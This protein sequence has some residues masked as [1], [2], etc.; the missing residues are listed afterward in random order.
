MMG[1]RGGKFHRDDKTLGRRRWATHHWI[2]C[3]L[4]WKGQH[5]EPMG[6]GYTS[7]FVLDEGQITLGDQ[8]LSIARP[9]P[10]ELHG[11]IMSR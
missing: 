1:N 9:H 8:L 11:R 5:H 6:Q 4:Y 3:E 7:L 2:C 10:Q